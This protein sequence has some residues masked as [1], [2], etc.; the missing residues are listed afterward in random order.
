MGGQGCSHASRNR[1]ED[2]LAGLP[3]LIGQ[4]NA[5][6]QNRICHIEWVIQIVVKMARILDPSA[7]LNSLVQRA[8]AALDEILSAI[9]QPIQFMPGIR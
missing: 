2:A 6:R 3:D 5:I 7:Q 9:A 4:S 8:L 1:V